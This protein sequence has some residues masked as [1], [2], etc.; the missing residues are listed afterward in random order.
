MEE[1]NILLKDIKKKGETIEEKFKSTVEKTEN[2]IEK[3]KKEGQKD[4]EEENDILISEEKKEILEEEIINFE[5]EG[6][7]ISS[8]AQRTI[9]V[10]QERRRATTSKNKLA[11]N[12][13]PSES[14][15]LNATGEGEPVPLERKETTTFEEEIDNNLL[16]C[17]FIYFFET[18]KKGMF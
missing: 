1:E 16:N 11:A 4:Q 6:T 7:I 13:L 8:I 17:N 9:Q 15:P 14:N 10:V 12:N 3:E 18:P 2:K 5:Q